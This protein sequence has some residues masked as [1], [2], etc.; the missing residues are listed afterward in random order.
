MGLF[1]P[2]LGGL[3]LHI[4]E[5]LS[6]EADLKFEVFSRSRFGASP[7]RYKS[8]K[9]LWYFEWL[10]F[11][12][13]PL[14]TACLNRSQ[15]TIE[16]MCG[17]LLS[18]QYEEFID[19]AIQVKG[20]RAAHSDPASSFLI[21]ETLL[22]FHFLLTMLIPEGYGLKG[23]YQ[24]ALPHIYGSSF[25]LSKFLSGDPALFNLDPSISRVAKFAAVLSKLRNEIYRRL[26][27]LSIVRE[28]YFEDR[29]DRARVAAAAFSVNTQPTDD[30]ISEF[31][32]S[33]ELCPI[34]EAL[35][36]IGDAELRRGRASSRV[37]L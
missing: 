21:D 22:S 13:N 16:E 19:I 17:E 5:E 11:Q 9:Y 12:K 2:G 28:D 27:D 20:L 37:L 7:R 32:R 23:I 26:V 6:A 3:S 30:A 34:F 1:D 15:R 35:K 18:R 33:V 31:Y 25:T 14:F 4:P 36:G 8:D 29:Q 10:R 24:S